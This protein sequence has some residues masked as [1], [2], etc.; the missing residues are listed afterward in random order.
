M[1]RLDEFLEQ[2]YDLAPDAV[3]QEG[4]DGQLVIMTGLSLDRPRVDPNDFKDCFVL[5]TDLLKVS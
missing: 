2:I 3:I 1:Q 4:H 5:S